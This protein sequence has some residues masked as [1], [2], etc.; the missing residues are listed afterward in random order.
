MLVNYP[1]SGS[2]EFAA[3][4]LSSLLMRGKIV[5]EIRTWSFQSDFSSGM[6]VLIHAVCYV[7]IILF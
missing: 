2:L 7:K 1:L 3:R 6:A 5:A 4:I